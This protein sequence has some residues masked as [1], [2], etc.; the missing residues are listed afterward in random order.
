M[1]SAGA[2]SS[3]SKGVLLE[4]LLRTV[5]EDGQDNEQLGSYKRR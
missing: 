1:M 4:Q 3:G 5:D 2:P